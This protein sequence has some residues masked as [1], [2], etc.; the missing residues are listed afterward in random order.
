MICQ[1]D[2]TPD[3]SVGGGFIFLERRFVGP[4]KSVLK[5]EKTLDK[6]I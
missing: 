1:Q 3:G 4:K 5:Y 6:I 2:T